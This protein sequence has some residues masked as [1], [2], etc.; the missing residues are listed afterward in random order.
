MTVLVEQPSTD[1]AQ[2]D[3][4]AAWLLSFS[5]PATRNAYRTDLSQ[6][7][8]FLEASGVEPLDASRPLIEGWARGLE[9]RGLRPAS[10]ARKLAAVA[11]LLRLV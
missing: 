10:V 3:I 11:S 8:G 5:S 9:L 7:F 4:T 6:L 2:R 1:L